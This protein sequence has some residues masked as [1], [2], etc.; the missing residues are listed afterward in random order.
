MHS[1]HKPIAI[2]GNTHYQRDP[3]GKLDTFHGQKEEDIDCCR[4]YKQQLFVVYPF[5]Y[6]HGCKRAAALWVL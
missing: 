5:K 4:L 1:N 2:N 6:I 3:A